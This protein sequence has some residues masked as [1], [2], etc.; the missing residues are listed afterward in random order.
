MS[1]HD[2]WQPSLTSTNY[3]CPNDVMLFNCNNSYA[4][5]AAAGNGF[6]ESTVSENTWQSHDIQQLTHNKRTGLSNRIVCSR[7][8]LLA[9]EQ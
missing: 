3:L 6:V 8:V 5:A 2:N 1:V 4:A 7:Y 9:L